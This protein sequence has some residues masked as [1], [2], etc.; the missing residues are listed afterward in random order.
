MQ[1]AVELL[2]IATSPSKQRLGYGTT[3]LKHIVATSRAQGLYRFVA[4]V[5]R[6]SPAAESFWGVQALHC[7]LV[8]VV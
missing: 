5:D 8:L 6:S 4:A 7:M 1:S 3:L 2:Y